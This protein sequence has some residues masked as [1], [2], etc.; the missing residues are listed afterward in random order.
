MKVVRILGIIQMADL[1][2]IAFEMHVLIV[3]KLSF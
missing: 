1:S 3:R 2:S